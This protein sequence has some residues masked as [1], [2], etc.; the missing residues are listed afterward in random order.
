[1][2]IRVSDYILPVLHLHCLRVDAFGVLPVKKTISLIGGG[3]LA[4]HCGLALR[5]RLSC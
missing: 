4:F 5:N 2:G 3:K 1:M